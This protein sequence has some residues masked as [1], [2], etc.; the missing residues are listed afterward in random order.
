MVRGVRSMTDPLRWIHKVGIAVGN[1]LVRRSAT[2]RRYDRTPVRSRPPGTR[3]RLDHPR[4]PAATTVELRLELSR[5]PSLEVPR[6][7]A[8]T[9]GARPSPPRRRSDSATTPPAA[10]SR[11]RED[12]T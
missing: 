2:F 8:R 3:E 12:A 6:E 4:G 7:H 5:A 9:R 10:T 11:T 1:L